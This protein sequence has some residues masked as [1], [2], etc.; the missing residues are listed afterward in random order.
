MSLH[1]EA[2]KNSVV[3]EMPLDVYEISRLELEGIID[4]NPS[5]L[6]KIKDFYESRVQDT[7]RKKQ[8]PD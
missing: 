4:K 3:A 5:L 8:F 2:E 6:Q 7:I 1:Q